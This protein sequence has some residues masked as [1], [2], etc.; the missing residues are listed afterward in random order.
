[1]HNGSP[2]EIKIVNLHPELTT[3][4]LTQLMETVGPTTRVEIKYN[5]HGKSIG[6]A[7]V[8]Y[9]FGRDAMEAIKRFDGRL[10][11]GQIISVSSTMPLI[12]RIGGR[13]EPRPRRR[14]PKPVT[15]EGNG[16]GNAKPDG[17]PKPKR[18]ERKT[19]EDLDNE[20]NMYM[21]GEAGEVQSEEQSTHL[22]QQDAEQASATVLVPAQESEAAQVPT[23]ESA[24][25]ENGV[26][27]AGNDVAME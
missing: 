27:P 13:A 7:F 15:V 21:N 12:D 19:L 23:Q 24:P 9:E 17:N 4:D 2:N 26:E 11:A 20:L 18:K 10:A 6:V 5:T 14:N 8:E 25:V 1:M 16:N 3:E 22:P